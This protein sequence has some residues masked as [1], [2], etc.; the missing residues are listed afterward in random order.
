M[1]MSCPVVFFII[2]DLDMLFLLHTTEAEYMRRMG[3]ILCTDISFESGMVD[4]S[5]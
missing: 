4:L 3:V 2:P 5:Q 1:S